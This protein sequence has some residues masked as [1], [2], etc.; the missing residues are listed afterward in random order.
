MG[1]IIDPASRLQRLIK[2]QSPRFAAGFQ[3][4]VSVDARMAAH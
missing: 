1:D 2:K 4:L 3:L